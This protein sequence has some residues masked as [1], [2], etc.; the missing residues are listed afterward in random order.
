[1]KVRIDK[2]LKISDKVHEFLATV[3]G[4]Q[5]GMKVFVQDWPEAKAWGE[6]DE[7]EAYVKEGGEWINKPKDGGAKGGGGFKPNPRKD[8][9][10]A[11]AQVHMAKGVS[12]EVVLKDAEAYLSWLTR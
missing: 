5:R 12:P 1:M 8:A 9:L 10:A 6:G 7:I 2:V 11:A 3:N 4:T